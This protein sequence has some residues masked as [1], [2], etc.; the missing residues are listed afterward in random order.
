MDPSSNDWRPLEEEKLDKDM[1]PVKMKAEMGMIQQKQRNTRDG[2]QTTRSWGQAWNRFSLAAL[3]RSRP[4]P[5]PI[6]YFQP[7]ELWPDTF[8]SFEPF[9]RWSFVPAVPANVYTLVQSVPSKRSLL[10]ITISRGV[11]FVS[12]G[13]LL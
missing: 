5:H 13:H 4:C 11:T 10:I 12:R 3:R 7:P 6:W 2:H 8:L 9:S 1:H